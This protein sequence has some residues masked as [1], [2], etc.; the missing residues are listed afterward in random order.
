MLQLQQSD[1][2]QYADIVAIS[3][4]TPEVL[5]RLAEAFPHVVFLPD[6]EKKL[7][8][9][10][11]V[12]EGRLRDV[13]APRTL[14]YYARAALKGQR[15]WEAR[16]DGKKAEVKQLGGNFVV[17]TEGMLRLAHPSSEPADRPS[18]EA[19]IAAVRGH[20]SQPHTP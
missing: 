8:K 15:F 17:D 6:P 12:G 9:L 7:Y 4:E 2:A 18:A 19:L 14:L 3:L 16:P 13:L 10:Y 1:L 11:G 5:P 20:R